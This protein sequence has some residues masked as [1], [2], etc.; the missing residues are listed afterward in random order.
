MTPIEAALKQMETTRAHGAP[1]QECG[2]L[3]PLGRRKEGIFLIG[4]H[5]CHSPIAKHGSTE[6]MRKTTANM[7]F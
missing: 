5:G 3:S 7:H 1:A 2:D 4:M 6:S